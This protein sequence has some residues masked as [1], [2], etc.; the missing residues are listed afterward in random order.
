MGSASIL[1]NESQRPFG[2]PDQEEDRPHARRTVPPGRVWPH[3]GRGPC[4]PE[5]PL[6]WCWILNERASVSIAHDGPVHSAGRG[7]RGSHGGSGSLTRSDRPTAP[8]TGA[9]GYSFEPCKT[10]IVL[11]IN[12]CIAG[13]AL[14]RVGGRHCSRFATM[15]TSARRKWCVRKVLFEALAGAAGPVTWPGLYCST[16]DTRVTSKNHLK[17]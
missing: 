6:L 1:E 8:L 15:L 12:A 11:Q 17:L 3:A 4:R 9:F 14:F 2:S 16:R 7:S 5:R 10:Q 13:N